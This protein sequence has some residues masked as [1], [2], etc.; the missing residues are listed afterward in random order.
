M[1]GIKIWGT[2][3]ALNGYI[4]DLRVNIVVWH[5]NTASFLKRTDSGIIFLSTVLN[6]FVY[7]VAWKLFKKTSFV[8]R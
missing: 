2:F 5:L 4:L 6:I 3:I 7:T 8:Y 1:V